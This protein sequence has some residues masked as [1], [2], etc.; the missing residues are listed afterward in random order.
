MKKTQLTLPAG[1]RMRRIQKVSSVVRAFFLAALVVEG[2][3]MA[4]GLFVIPVAMFHSSLTES[5]N[6][7]NNYSALLSLPFGFMASL[8][9]FRLFSRLREGHLF[10]APTIQYLQAAG[11]WWIIAGLVQVAF[12]ALGMF[13]YTPNNVVITDSGGIFGGLIVFFIAWVL[14][15]GQ[16]L[17]DEQELTV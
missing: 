12:K 8:N 2:A 4:A 10:E 13:I 9:F 3:G 1:L 16:E 6:A 15:E 17:K 5:Y 7:F 11:K 14:R